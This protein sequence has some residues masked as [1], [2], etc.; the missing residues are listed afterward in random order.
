VSP[1]FR[2]VVFACLEPICS[3]GQLLMDLY[4]NFDCDPDRTDAVLLERMFRGLIGAVTAPD[5]LVEAAPDPKA[6]GGPAGG[7][8][9][10]G[11]GS[12][13][14]PREQ[15][16]ALRASALACLSRMLHALFEWHQLRVGASPCVCVLSVLALCC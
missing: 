12:A 15:R 2:S 13:P 4:V 5:A 11:G 14:M 9:Q 10:Y 1:D 6:V 7:G 8:G 16:L 3:D